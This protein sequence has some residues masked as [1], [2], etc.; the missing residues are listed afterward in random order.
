MAVQSTTSRVAVVI[1][2]DT[3]EVYANFT[4][5]FVSEWDFLLALGSTHLGTDETN[6]LTPTAR[7]DVLVRM[8]PQHAKAML[9]TLTELV[10][11]YENDHGPINPKEAPNGEEQPQ[12]QPTRAQRRRNLK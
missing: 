1:P 2:P 11:T 10:T 4:Q 8:S 6:K 7:A 5:V 3:L 12:P 9:A